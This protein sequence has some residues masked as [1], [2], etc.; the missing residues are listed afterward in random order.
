MLPLFG[1]H[2]KQPGWEGIT[3]SHLAGQDGIVSG[4]GATANHHITHPPEVHEQP[5]LGQRF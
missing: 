1:S 3:I 2:I 4:E 5:D